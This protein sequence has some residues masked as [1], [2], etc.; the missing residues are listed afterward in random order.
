MFFKDGTVY[1]S[2]INIMLIDIHIYSS[3]EN[4]YVSVQNFFHPSGE[5]GDD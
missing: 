3:L 2:V 4:R 1:G 5:Y